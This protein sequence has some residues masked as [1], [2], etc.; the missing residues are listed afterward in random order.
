MFGRLNFKREKFFKANYWIPSNNNSVPD[1]KKH[2]DIINTFKN[3]KFIFSA[4]HM[5]IFG[6]ISISRKKQS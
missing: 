2:L 1:Y 5:T 4:R 6:Q 3:T